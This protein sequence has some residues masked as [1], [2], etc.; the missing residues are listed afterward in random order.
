MI[1]WTL[2]PSHRSTCMGTPP[3]PPHRPPAHPHQY[4]HSLL[5]STS[6]H[7]Q[8][9]DMKE[10]KHRTP[11]LISVTA[12]CLVTCLLGQAGCSVTGL[13]PLPLVMAVLG[14]P[15]LRLQPLLTTACL[16]KMKLCLL[17]LHNSCRLQIP[18]LHPPTLHW[19]TPHPLLPSPLSPIY[20]PHTA[21]TVAKWETS[22][23]P[24]SPHPTTTPTLTLST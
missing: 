20:K 21:R 13:H 12:F 8:L 5:N 1:P 17:L 2:L 6:L 15:H 11:C 4:H 14:R 9:Q 23:C 3:L 7:Q 22:T 10:W 24:H 18:A 19:H 16:W